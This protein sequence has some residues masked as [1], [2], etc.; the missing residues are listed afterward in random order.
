MGLLALSS[1]ALI[2]SIQ[3]LFTELNGTQGIRGHPVFSVLQI[4][5]FLFECFSSQTKFLILLNLRLSLQA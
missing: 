5:C 4:C 3:N 1:V 2:H